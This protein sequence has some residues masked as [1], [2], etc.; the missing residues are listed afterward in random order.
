MLERFFP[1]IYD[2]VMQG[3]DRGEMAA[4]RRRIVAA[5]GGRTIEIAVGTGLGLRHYEAGASVVAI[6]RDIEMLRRA[7][8]RAN[9]AAA[10]VLLVVADAECLPFR[11]CA[12]ET[13][14]A[15]LALCTIPHPDRALGELRR[16]LQSSGALRV[17]EHV[18]VAQPIVARMQDWLTP[19][20]RSVAG[21]CHLN[22]RTTESIAAA[23]FK[24]ESVVP[25]AGGLFLEISAHAPRSHETKH[26]TNEGLSP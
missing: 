4:W 23:G 16:V 18:R 26:S 8:R 21:G 9:R 1:R 3:S 25:H 11:S 6:D 5:A 13:G 24:I 7:R 20:W 19:I 15:E 10:Q 2:V 12:F 22:R 17:L 14:I